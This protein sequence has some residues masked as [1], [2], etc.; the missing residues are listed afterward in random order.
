VILVVL[1]EVASER[2]ASAKALA[3]KVVAVLAVKH[4]DLKP[5]LPNCGFRDP[6][7]TILA[8][9]SVTPN[10][11]LAGWFYGELNAAEGLYVRHTCGALRLFSGRSCQQR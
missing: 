10:V 5:K 3:A 8:D 2:V 1:G 4:Q 6:T 7:N 9:F 11:I